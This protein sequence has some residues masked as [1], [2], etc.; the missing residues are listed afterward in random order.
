VASGFVE[1][2]VIVLHSFAHRSGSD[3]GGFGCGV[4]FQFIQKFKAS[5]L[6][7]F[8]ISEYLALMFFIQVVKG[9]YFMTEC[10]CRFGSKWSFSTKRGN[11]SIMIADG[12]AP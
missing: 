10:S 3:E 7:F 1:K 11:S 4:Q 8:E 5:L 6:I 2:P 12:T 9:E